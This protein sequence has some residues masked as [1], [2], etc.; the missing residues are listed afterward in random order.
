MRWSRDGTGAGGTRLAGRSW[1]RVGPGIVALLAVV[2]GLAG[3]CRRSR[4]EVIEQ[5]RDLRG[6]PFSIR[7]WAEP[8]DELW[9]AIGEAFDR[10]TALQ[11]SL[12]EWIPDSDVSRINEAAGSDTP[13]P[14]SAEMMR[15]LLAAREVSQ[16]SGGAFDVTWAVLRQAWGSFESADIDPLSKP[17]RAKVERL[18]A[19]VGWEKLELDEAAGTA[20][21]AER[22]MQLGLGG[23]AKGFAIDE[24]ASV[25]LRRGFLDF[26]IDAGGDVM[27]HGRRHGRDW[28]VGLRHPRGEP[29]ETFAILAVRDR[30]VATTGDYEHFM[31][32]SGVRWPHVINPHT[33]FPATGCVS[34]T[35]IHPSAMFADALATAAFV[36]GPAAGI[37]LI[38][39]S[40]GADAVIVDPNLGVHVTP[41]LESAVAV[42]WLKERKSD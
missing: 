21:L 33:G 12:N 22:G 18:R 5:T 9:S 34:V 39:N 2:A 24:A 13:V 4:A 23:I 29:D 3:G 40:P 17:F 1:G 42:R 36:L 35:V 27:V 15:V 25:L 20:R 41:G 28:T 19:K 32:A 11:Q 14:I 38:R 16:R 37:E 6:I 26:A 30:A 7:V 8:S 31:I 10:V